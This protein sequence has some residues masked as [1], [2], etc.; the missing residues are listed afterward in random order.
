MNTRLLV[1]CYWCYSFFTSYLLYLFFVSE[2]AIKR[3]NSDN[4]YD[5]VQM[6]SSDLF[7]CLSLNGPSCGIMFLMLFSKNLPKNCIS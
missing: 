5:R 3:N 7:A 6:R 2:S 4:K 1:P